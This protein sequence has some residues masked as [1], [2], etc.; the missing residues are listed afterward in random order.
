MD[1]GAGVGRVGR[2][3][4]RGWL[5]IWVPHSSR[6][7]RDGW[8]SGSFAT[9]PG[10]VGFDFDAAGFAGLPVEET[11]PGPV[12]GFFDQAAFYRV[13]MDV[14]ELLDELGLGEDVEVVIARLP[15]LGA[16]TPEELGGFALE[17]AEGGGE[18]MTFGL[19]EQQVDV[20]GHQ[21]V[22][23]EEESVALA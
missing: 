5:Q 18:W 1:S 4:S 15:E 12:F 6:H 21:D 13:V 17:D 2:K 10:P 11:A 9:A 7:P 20:L 8:G 23:E 3:E 19:A 16:R 14:A 22:A